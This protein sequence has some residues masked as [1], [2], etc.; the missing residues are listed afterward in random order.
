V[1]SKAD[2]YPDDLNTNFSTELQQLHS[3]VRHKFSAT[4]KCKTGFTH[5][6]LYKIIVENNIECIF[7]NVDIAFRIFLTLIV[8]N[9][10][11]ERSFSHLKYIKNPIRTTMQQSRLDALPLLN[12]EADVLRKINLEDLQDVAIKKVGENF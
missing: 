6:E 8:T 10:S 2:A 1:L 7:P 5:T 9:C 11:T 12:I 4:Q 3:Y